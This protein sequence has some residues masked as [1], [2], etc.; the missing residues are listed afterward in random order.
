MIAAAA[1]K[2][3][4]ANRPAIVSAAST[5]SALLLDE[6]TATA[7]APVADKHRAAPQQSLPNFGLIIDY[8]LEEQPHHKPT[9]DCSRRFYSI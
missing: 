5:V 6:L 1:N 4:T 9:I 7:A 8:P 2:R 3:P